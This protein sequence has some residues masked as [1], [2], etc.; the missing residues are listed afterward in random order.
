[1]LS[2][3][4]AKADDESKPSFYAISSAPGGPQSSQTIFSI[5]TIVQTTR[6]L[7]IVS[8]GSLEFLIKDVPSN[9]WITGDV[10][11]VLVQDRL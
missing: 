8:S 1:M 6:M 11:R 3:F 5:V 4:E 2:L 10:G 7:C 9:D